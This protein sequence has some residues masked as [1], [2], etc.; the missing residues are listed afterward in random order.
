MAKSEARAR[1]RPSGASS[2]REYRRKRDFT[3]TAE[4]RPL[5][6]GRSAP[7]GIFVIQ[8]HFARRLHYDFRLEMDGV[9]KS[10]AVPKGPS[11]KKGER[12]LA[13]QTEDHPLEYATFEGEIPKGEYGAGK[14]EVWDHGAWAPIGDPAEGLRKGHLKFA[15]QGERLTGIWALVRMGGR[16]SGDDS[17]SG[18][19]A[20]SGAGAPPSKENWL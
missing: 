15:I 18:A 1:K 3:R 17:R 2:L 14:V 13:V 8:R 6:R 20:N 4:P 11:L 16:R 12:R 10:W 5:V 7:G 19:G 9:L